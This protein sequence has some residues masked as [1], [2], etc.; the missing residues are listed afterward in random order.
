MVIKRIRTAVQSAKAAVEPATGPSASTKSRQDK[1]KVARALIH[2][3]SQRDLETNLTRHLSICRDGGYRCVVV[4]NHFPTRLL[5]RS[6]V[7]F[8]YAP[9]GATSVVYPGQVHASAHFFERLTHVVAF[10]S[11]VSCAWSGEK[12][13]EVMRVAKDYSPYIDAMSRPL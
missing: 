8:E 10:W 13:S 1:K 12:A 9:L 11:V 2:V 3:G 5:E 6:D 4:S 7:I